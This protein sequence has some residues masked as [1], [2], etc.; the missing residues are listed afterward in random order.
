[1]TPSY[2]LRT[3][4]RAE[5]LPL[6]EQFHGYKSLSESLTY[7]FAVYER[8]SPIAAFAWQPP[9]PGAAKALCADAPYAVLSLSRMVARPKAQ[10]QLK[11]ISKP[12]RRQMHHMIDRG[13]WP[14]LVTYHD[15]GQGHNG[16][17]YECSGWTK[18]VRSRRPVFTTSDGRRASSYSW[19]HRICTVIPCSLWLEWH[20]WRRVPTNRRWKSGTQAFTYSKDY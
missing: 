20:G 16:F 9:P 7:C 6:F 14:V 10:R 5:V 18:T 19:E 17:V 4:T 13:R 3:R 1:M 11:H 8:N 15:E 2:D 12:L